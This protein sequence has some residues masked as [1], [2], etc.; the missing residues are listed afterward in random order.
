MERFL[1]AYI[2]FVVR[3]PAA[4]AVAVSLVTALAAAW[5]AVFEPIELDTSFT[6][7]LPDD[8]PC[9]VESRR[10]SKLVGSTDYLIIAIE[11]PD[12]A[13]NMA[14]ADDIAKKLADF[15]EV[16]WVATEEDKSFFRDRLIQQREVIQVLDRASEDGD[17][18][19]D[20]MKH[21][22]AALTDYRLS[23]EA[24][25]AIASGDLRWIN[26][27]VGELTQRQL[28]FIYKRLEC[29]AW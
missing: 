14:F 16:E 3:R 8:L 21:G 18:W 7:L 28:M 2:G 25:A 5:L 4:V 19:D 26:E 23:G 13:D 15:S 22:S 27:N 6:T 24:K 9:V 29:E 12:P 11:S 20:L 10:V 1:S 17:F